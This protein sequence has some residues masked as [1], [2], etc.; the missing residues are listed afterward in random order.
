METIKSLIAD[1]KKKIE[2]FR[3]NIKTQEDAIQEV[4]IVPV[5]DETIYI[6]QI[7][8]LKAKIENNFNPS[9]DHKFSDIF[10]LNDGF[11]DGE[12]TID[13][14]DSFL[15]ALSTYELNSKSEISDYLQDLNLQVQTVKDFV[16]AAKNFDAY[17]EKKKQAEQTQKQ[18]AET[19]KMFRNVFTIRSAERKAF[20]AA[21]KETLLS[22]NMIKTAGQ[23]QFIKNMFQIQMLKPP[24]Y[25]SPSQF[26]ALDK[27]L[28]DNFSWVIKGDPVTVFGSGD[29]FSDSYNGLKDKC[30][31]VDV[32][33][34]KIGFNSFPELNA[35]MAK[36]QTVFVLVN[37]K[38]KPE[39]EFEWYSANV[40]P[41]TSAEIIDSQTEYAGVSNF[42]SDAYPKVTKVIASLEAKTIIY[43]DNEPEIYNLSKMY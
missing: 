31:A 37:F 2:I 39:P 11:T 8:A 3:N 5:V 35:M 42:F 33:G 19:L 29:Q 22:T 25:L 16:D 21:V 41:Y 28:K 32:R 13:K 26:L 7:N 1:E 27:K 20:E 6:N 36:G 9:K 23:R 43:A 12:A 15:G 14:A 30:T 34:T 38:A 24:L 40:V 18:M 10:E 4:E 17:T